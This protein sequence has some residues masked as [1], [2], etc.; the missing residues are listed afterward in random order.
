MVKNASF[1]IIT[2]KTVKRKPELLIVSIIAFK[3]IF[4]N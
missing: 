3:I 2:I 1:L 4:Y